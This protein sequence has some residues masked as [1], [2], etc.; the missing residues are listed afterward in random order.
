MTLLRDVLTFLA[1]A[2]AL[3]WPFLALELLGR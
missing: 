2:L 3:G 1:G